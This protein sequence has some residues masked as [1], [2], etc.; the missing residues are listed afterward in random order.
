MK[1]TVSIITISYN[2][3]QVIEETI[4]SVLSQTYTDYEYIFIDGLSKDGTVDIIRSYLDRF[5]EKGI[6]CHLVSEPD[7]GIYDAMNKG[8]DRA[9]GQWVIMMN[10]GD[11]FLDGQVLSDL[12]SQKDYSADILYG[13]TVYSDVCRGTSYYKI[14]PAQPLETIKKGIPFCH[15]SVFVRNKIIKKYR[16]D[17][18]YRLVAD[19]DMF[20]RAYMDGVQFHHIQRLIALYDCSGITMQNPKKAAEE[21]ARVRARAGTE[22]PTSSKN[23]AVLI[24]KTLLRSFLKNYFPGILFSPKRGWHTSVPRNESWASSNE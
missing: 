10:A 11:R 15:Q 7:K 3:E 6:A 4:C 1:P 21:S 9:N 23:S 24:S 5:A 13:D 17:T 8:I 18:A 14:T 2:A 20:L 12:F 16:F 19:F 22:T